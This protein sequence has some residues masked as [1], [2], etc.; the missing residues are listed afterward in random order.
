MMN[1]YMPGSKPVGW[2][3]TLVQTMQPWPCFVRSSNQESVSVF[4]SKKSKKTVISLGGDL[5]ASV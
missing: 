5:W 1:K 4:F 3:G 2:T